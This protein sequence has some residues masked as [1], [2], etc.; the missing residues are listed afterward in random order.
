MVFSLFGTAYADTAPAASSAANPGAGGHGFDVL[1]FVPFILILIVMYFLLIRPQ[2]K[3]MKQHADMVAA[4]R[5][6]DKVIIAGGIIGSI[7]KIVNNEEIMVEIAEGT[8][9]RVL[10]ASVSQVL[11]KTE[12]VEVTTPPTDKEKASVNDVAS[13]ETEAAT[14]KIDSKKTTKSAGASKKTNK[15]KQVG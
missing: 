8:Y 12:P 6:G 14:Q 4:L 9:I 1:S 11:A 2:Q 15:T 13:P 10:K 3:K 5:R 7:H